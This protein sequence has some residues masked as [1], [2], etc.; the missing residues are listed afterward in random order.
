MKGVSAV[1]ATI[2]MLMITIALAGLAYLYISGIFTAKTGVVIELD[3][4]ATSCSVTSISVFVRN[5]GTI[6]T[7]ADKVTL[8]GTNSTGSPITFANSGVCDAATVQLAAGGSS[9]QCTLATATGSRGT[10]TIVV[11][12]PANTVR[13]TVYCPG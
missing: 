7:T 13:G 8:S 3:E 11:Y 6:V 10:N 5:T 9:R 12:G 2:L 1:I 4:S